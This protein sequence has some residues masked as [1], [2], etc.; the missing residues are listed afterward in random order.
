MIRPMFTTWFS[1]QSFVPPISQDLNRCHLGKKYWEDAKFTKQTWPAVSS[2]SCI[3][4]CMHSLWCILTVLLYIL[5]IALC[6]TYRP[7]LLNYI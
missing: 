5:C 3:R 1:G 4:I 7:R 2:E 6:H